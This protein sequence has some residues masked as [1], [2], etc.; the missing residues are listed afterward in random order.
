MRYGKGFANK[1]PIE[2]SAIAAI[3][4]IGYNSPFQRRT[5]RYEHIEKNEESVCSL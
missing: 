2:I 4:G 5:P 3:T 1:N